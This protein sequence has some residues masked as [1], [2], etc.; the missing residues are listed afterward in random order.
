MLSLPEAGD[1]AVP[2]VKQ[3]DWSWPIHQEVT[4]TYGLSPN[5]LYH[6]DCGQNMVLVM[7]ISND[8]YN[9]YL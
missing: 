8:L 3:R 7:V 1:F 6:L 9:K 2:V 5:D 4:G